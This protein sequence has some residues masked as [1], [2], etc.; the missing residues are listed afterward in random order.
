MTTMTISAARQN[1]VFTAIRDWT[2]SAI[3][4]WRVAANFRRTA[5]ELNALSDR[6]LADIGITRDQ[7]TSVAFSA[8]FDQED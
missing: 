5:A 3:T 8:S 7:I 2:R 4:N 1:W 6:E